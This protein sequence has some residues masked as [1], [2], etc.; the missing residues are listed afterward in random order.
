MF[1][2][3]APR[4]GCRYLF[5]HIK[6]VPCNPLANPSLDTLKLNNKQ[7]LSLKWS[8][9]QVEI[10]ILPKI[11]LKNSSQKLLLVSLQTK[12]WNLWWAHSDCWRFFKWWHTPSSL[13]AYANRYCTNI[14]Y[15]LSLHLNSVT[16][17]VF[18]CR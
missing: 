4:N 10:F 13:H 17:I 5:N 9:R 7:S 16:F 6:K 2:G 15:R 18:T 14:I 3:V 11:I 1:V 12:K 8:T